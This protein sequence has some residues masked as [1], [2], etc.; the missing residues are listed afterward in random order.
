[1][2]RPSRCPAE[3]GPAPTQ[4]T[5]DQQRII[6]C[7]AASG[8]RR[9]PS[10]Q[11]QFLEEII[12]LVVDD[13]EGREIHHLDARSQPLA[14]NRARSVFAGSDPNPL[15]SVAEQCCPLRRQLEGREKIIDAIA[16]QRLVNRGNIGARFFDPADECQRQSGY[17]Q[18]MGMRI[19]AGGGLDAPVG[20]LLESTE[21]HKRQ[22]ARA[23]HAEEQ[24]IEWTQLT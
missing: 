4:W 17:R 9:I 22:A 14:I 20:G 1:V 3:P 23:E 10:A 11:I 12:A 24:G 19:W 7:C 15:G 6:S 18:N 8:A 21:T 5:P 13:D 16:R 2:Q